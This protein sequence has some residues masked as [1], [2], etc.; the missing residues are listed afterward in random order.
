MLG[1]RVKTLRSYEFL[2]MAHWARTVSTPFQ[3]SAPKRITDEHFKDAHVTEVPTKNI[4]ARS[5]RNVKE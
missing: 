5:L 3:V 1:G 2:A 4:T